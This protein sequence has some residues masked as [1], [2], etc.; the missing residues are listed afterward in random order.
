MRVEGGFF[1]GILMDMMPSLAMN[2]KIPWGVLATCVVVVLAVFLRLGWLNLRPL[3]HDEGVN[4]FFANQIVQAAHFRYD[5]TNYHGPFYFFVLA[6]SFLVLGVSEFSLRLPAALF[7]IGIVLLP[8]FFFSRRSSPPRVAAVFLLLSPSLLFFSRYSIH[9]SALVFFSLLGVLLVSRIIQQQDFFLLPMLFA[10]IALLLTTKETAVIVI[11]AMGVMALVHW[12][13]LVPAFRRPGAVEAWILALSVFSLLYVALFT[14]FFTNP[15][16]LLDS[17]QGLTPWMSRGIEGGGHNKPF[18]YYLLMLW[19]YETPLLL[20]GAAG[21]WYAWRSVV[22]RCLAIWAL[23][24]L[25]S[26]S[27]IGYKTPWLVINFVVP[28]AMLGAVGYGGVPWQGMKRWCLGVSVTYLAVTSGLFNFYLPWQVG[29][30]YA[31]E[32]TDADI[33][34]LVSRVNLMEGDD[35]KILVNADD[36]WPLPFYLNGKYAEYPGGTAVPD[37]SALAKFTFLIVQSTTFDRWP[38]HDVWRTEE[39]TLR[40]G[41]ILLYAQPVQ[42]GE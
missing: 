8:W 2:K 41:V 39:F 32:H 18:W 30:P 7:G 36:Y 10:V 16:G 37:A 11:S 9:E 3:H 29:N 22:G 15:R 20:F 40:P 38:Q 17:F 35:Q 31:Y 23:T 21:L 24:I 1:C 25:V 28:L 34:R 12:R 4:Y 33:L 13:A 42:G 14:S 26:Y 6:L 27:V 5:P 19:R